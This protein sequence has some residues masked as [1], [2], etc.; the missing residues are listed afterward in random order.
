M[1]FFTLDRFTL[2]QF[3]ATALLNVSPDIISYLLM[4][5]TF[6]TSYSSQ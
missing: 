3:T 5:S 1:V 4:V 2:G 6:S